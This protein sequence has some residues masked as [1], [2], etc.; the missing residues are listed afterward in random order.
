MPDLNCH[1]DVFVLTHTFFFFFKLISHSLDEE[2]LHIS[3][4]LMPSQTGCIRWLSKR[5]A[6]DEPEINRF[7]SVLMLILLLNLGFLK[8]C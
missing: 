4:S 5:G 2:I 8:N 1:K 3:G 7:E 6:G